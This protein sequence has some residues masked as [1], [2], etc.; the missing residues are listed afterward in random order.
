MKR[1]L[2]A[3]VALI[4]TVTLAHCAAKEPESSAP[5]VLP[6]EIAVL[7]TGSPVTSFAMAKARPVAATLSQDRKLRILSLPTGAE[8][9][10]IDL[11]G[12]DIDLLALSPDGL[13]VAIGDHKG[14]VSVWAA[15]TAQPRFELQLSHYP[16]LAVF[17]RNGTMLAIAAQGDAV[18]LID[19]ASGRPATT[20][21]SPAGGTLTLAFSP[22]DRLVATGDG[23]S[24]VRIYETATGRRIAENR[25]FL[26]VPLALG[27]TADGASVIAGGGDKT[28]T[29]IDAA[30]GTTSRRMDRTTQPVAFVEVSPDGRSFTTG[31]M[32]S[33]NMTLPDRIVIHETS[34]GRQQ[35]DWLPPSLPV[36]AGW[37][38]DGRMLV[39][40][41]T[42]DALHLWQLR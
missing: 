15:D 9:H 37:T 6:A 3:G 18:Q 11:A 17:S 7:K 13:S 21:G 35:V 25:D 40:T 2:H 33:E 42:A 30:T 26:M 12:R 8:R 22:D 29:F 24:V 31:F 16:G 28:V 36:G 23:D 1:I 41:A 14:G 32:K 34:A 39:A 38:G 4:A 20:L 27:F 10:A 5:P 19:V